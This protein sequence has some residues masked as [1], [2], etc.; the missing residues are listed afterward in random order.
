MPITKSHLCS[1]CGEVHVVQLAHKESIDKRKLS[2][3]K[4]AATWV[5]DNNLNDFKKKDLDLSRFGQSAYG[6]FGALRYHALIAKVRDRN[7][8]KPIKGR[9]LVTRQGWAFLR[10]ELKISKFVLV[11]DNHIVPNSH[12]QQTIGVRDVYYGSEAITTHFE[13]FD[14]DNKPVAI[15]PAFKQENKQNALFNLEPQ[16]PAR[17]HFV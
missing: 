9:W 14:E 8:K 1:E 17:K 15:R 3:L 10:G 7:T 16:K 2:M 11:K 12:S 5:I 4:A 13:Y 6:N